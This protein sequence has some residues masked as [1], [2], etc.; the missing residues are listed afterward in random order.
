MISISCSDSIHCKFSLYIFLRIVI[1]FILTILM[2]VERIQ[3]SLNMQIDF[4]VFQIVLLTSSFNVVFHFFIISYW[5]CL[6]II[7]NSIFCIINFVVV[8]VAKVISL[9][10]KTYHSWVFLFMIVGNVE[11]VKSSILFGI[12]WNIYWIWMPFF[13]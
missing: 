5:K 7:H 6:I 2:L 1:N 9:I 3:L 10:C 4:I 13:I 8:V 12:V 11:S